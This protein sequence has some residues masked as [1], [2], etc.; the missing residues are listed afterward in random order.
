MTSIAADY[1]YYALGAMFILVPLLLPGGVV[2]LP[3]VIGKLNQR[4]LAASR[5]FNVV[6]AT[7]TPEG[8]QA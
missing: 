3:Q 2:S 6:P 1:W 4:R 7:G 8:G 5:G